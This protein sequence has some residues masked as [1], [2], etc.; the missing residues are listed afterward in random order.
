MKAALQESG[1]SPTEAPAIE[2]AERFWSLERAEAIGLLRYG[3]PPHN[4]FGWDA[5]AELQARLDEIEAD[6]ELCVV[7]LASAVDGIF[8]TGLDLKQLP[9][10]EAAM[11][12]QLDAGGRASRRVEAFPKPVI[13]AIDGACYGGALELVLSC[14]LRV[15]SETARFAQPEV[16]FGIMPGGGATQRLPRLIGKGRALA[17][18]LTGAKLDVDEATRSGLVD[19]RVAEGPAL[20]EALRLAR[21]IA[22]MDAQVVEAILACVDRGSRLPL[23]EALA[24]ERTAFLEVLRRSERVRL[25]RLREA[26]EAA[27]E[28]REG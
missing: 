23:D 25:Q 1:V 5:M 18:L 10:G 19:V 13:A 2:A 26:P 8:G 7:V 9:D 24:L 3:N 16:I 28:R 14:H 12:Q 4:L 21:R 6:P 17:A 20:V 15:A 11:R 27:A 22:R